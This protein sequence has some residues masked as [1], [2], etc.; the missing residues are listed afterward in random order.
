MT[1]NQRWPRQKSA[2]FDLMRPVVIYILATERPVSATSG[3]ST[4][5][6]KSGS[7]T[8]TPPKAST[9]IRSLEPKSCSWQSARQCWFGA[10]KISP[11]S[12]TGVGARQSNQGEG[13]PTMTKATPDTEQGTPREVI[14]TARLRLTEM[15]RQSGPSR[16]ALDGCQ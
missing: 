10:R 1:R 4:A 2:A 5:R 6:R 14:A 7:D 13:K 8:T 9:P 15:R 16:S 3:T 12:S 11:G